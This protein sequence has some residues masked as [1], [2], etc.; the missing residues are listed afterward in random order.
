MPWI[1]PGAKPFNLNWGRNIGFQPVRPA[2]LLS[3]APLQQAKSL[4]G[5]QTESLCSDAMH[6]PRDIGLAQE[7]ESFTEEDRSRAVRII[8][9]EGES[10]EPA[11]VREERIG[12]VHIHLRHEQRGQ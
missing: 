5:T 6:L 7:L 1:T 3:A 11:R 12:E 9:M 2:D 8:D 10:G 4:L